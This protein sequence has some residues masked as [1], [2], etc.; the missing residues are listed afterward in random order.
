MDLSDLDWQRL[1]RYVS[2]RGT[3]E[4]LAELE[5]W[6][7]ASA[8]RRALAG[9]MRSAGR[10]PGEPA[11][12]WN[13]DAAW[14]HLSRRMRWFGQPPVRIGLGQGFRGWLPWATAAAAVLAVGSTF[15]A[16]ESRSRAER[17]RAEAAP[18]REIVT[19]RG[20]RAS[21]HLADGTAV[22]LGSESRLTIPAAYS[23]LGAPRDLFLEGEGYFEVVHDTLRP[24]RVRTP[25]G[26]AEDMGTEFVVTTYPEAGGMRVVVASGSVALRRQPEPA[27]TRPGE[28]APLLTLVQGELGRVDSAGTAT[29]TNTDPAPYLAW[30]RGTLAFDGIPLR[31]VVP[32]LARWYDLDIRLGDGTLAARQLTASFD[33]LSVSQVLDLMVLSLGLRVEREGRTVTLYPSAPRRR[34]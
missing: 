1:E 14:R 17:D 13:E 18:P 12:V 10:L 20:E 31:D 33:N 6:V 30:T 24:F 3:S 28:E 27:R 5:R 23:R 2:A 25:L 9:A 34:S 16:L 29:V 4:E 15:L 21:L 22:M 8:E 11:P 7:N 26:I 32:Q 19:R